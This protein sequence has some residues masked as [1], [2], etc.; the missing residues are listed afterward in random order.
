MMVGGGTIMAEMPSAAA[1]GELSGSR[2]AAL[3]AGAMIVSA[4]TFA[5]SGSE[6]G[7]VP[8]SLWRPPI[9]SE[10]S[11]SKTSGVDPARFGY[12]VARVPDALGS[13]ED[14]AART[15]EGSAPVDY[16]ERY[17]D[18]L[19][20]S[21]EGLRDDFRAVKDELRQTRQEVKSDL[22]AMRSEMNGYRWS[23]WSL[24]AAV[25]ALVVAVVIGL[26]QFEAQVLSLIPH[27]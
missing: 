3:M 1:H 8:Q 17:L 21:V 16:Q 6:P 7:Q 22:A 13:E 24:V 27:K 11:G 25:M 18:M 5:F 23:S 26:L 10:T 15:T 9:L 4:A 19:Q 2:G 20:K 14:V 12:D